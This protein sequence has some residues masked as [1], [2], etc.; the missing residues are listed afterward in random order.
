MG[1]GGGGGGEMCQLTNTLPGSFVVSTSAT[2]MPNVSALRA[3]F[4]HT[5]ATCWQAGHQ[6][7]K[8]MTKEKIISCYNTN[9]IQTQS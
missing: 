5:G 7:A 4:D 1:G 3:R 8:L 9:L 2:L 6:G